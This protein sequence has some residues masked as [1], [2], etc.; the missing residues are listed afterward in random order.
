MI[1]RKPFL[2]WKTPLNLSFKLINFQ[3]YNCTSSLHIY[4]YEYK[5]SNWISHK[6]KFELFEKRQILYQNVRKCIKNF[7]DKFQTII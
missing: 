3:A 6:L 4:Q 2:A 7:S 1:S 5:V